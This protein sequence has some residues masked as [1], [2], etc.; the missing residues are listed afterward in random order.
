MTKEKNMKMFKKLTAAPYAALLAVMAAL[1][2][3]ANAALAEGIKT[4]ITNGFSDVQEGAALIVVGF[5]ALFGIRLIMR[6]FGR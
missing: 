1:P 3:T 4:A 2:V 5:A 6:L